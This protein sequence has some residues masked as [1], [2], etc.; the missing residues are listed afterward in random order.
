MSTKYQ[1]EMN[2]SGRKTGFWVSGLGS[3]GTI[4]ST[5]MAMGCCAGLLAPLASVEAAALPFLDPSFQMPLLYATAALTLI[6]LVLSYLRQ[7][8]IFF[9]ILGLLGIVLLLIPFHTALEV[10]LF[11]LL[12]GLG[13]GSLI[14]ASWGPLV[15]RFRNGFA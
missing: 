5:S 15:W 10:S 1:V 7:R 3:L 2:N 11:Y 4:L 8:S 12:V 14:L 6:G 9:L 13:L